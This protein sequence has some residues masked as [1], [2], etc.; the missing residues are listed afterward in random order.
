MSKELVLRILSSLI[1]FPLLIFIIV[2]GSFYFF[3]F[4]IICFFIS[5]YEWQRMKVNNFIKILGI[6]FLI[7][8]FYTVLQI[9]INF[10]DEFW[11]L[12]LVLATC[13]LTDTGG[14]IFGKII[15]GP[16]L[17]KFSPNKTF[18]GVF[19][20]YFLCTIFILLIINF[21]FINNT[22]LINLVVFVFSISSVSQIGDIIISYFKRLS[23][24]K[25]TGK[26]IPGHGG[27]LDRIDGM[28]FSFPVAYL[29]LL[30]EF[31]RVI[32]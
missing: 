8:S 6:F 32:L 3:L 31:F 17:T 14:F 30:T 13:I 21:K 12:L 5:V 20:S 18:A 2:N 15:K 22:Y 19:G 29:L 24:F 25:D 1:L 26:L 10:N 23:N 16:K 7:Y 9:R 27:L 28:I 4:I 11:P